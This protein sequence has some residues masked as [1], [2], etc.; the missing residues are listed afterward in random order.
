MKRIYFTILLSAIVLMS[1]CKKELVEDSRSEVTDNY[2]STPDGIQAAVNAA[3]SL[4]R[5]YWGTEL[6]A[7]LSV[8]GTDEYTAGS[9]ADRD[10]N[11]YNNNLNPVKGN[12]MTAWANFY[13]GINACNAVINRAPDV[14]MD[15]TLKTTRVAEARFLRAQYYFMLVQMWGPVHITLT[16][17]K[18]AV[19]TAKRSPVAEV[20]KVITDDLD[21]AIANLPVTSTNYGRAIKPAAQHLAAKV[22]LTRAGINNDQADYT[23]AADLA[24]AV[25]NG[26]TNKLLDNFADIFVQGAGERNTETI[27]SVQYSNNLL[28]NG[29][30]NTLHLYFVFNYDL[31]PGMQR[32]L[33]GGRP[34]KRY[35]PT[36]FALNTL[37]NHQTDGR[38]DATFKRVYYSNKAGTYTING[39]QVN[40]KLGDTAIFFP[41]VE[42]TAAQ[43]ATK[44]Y[45]VFPP[46][47][48]TE[49][50]FP[51]LTKFLDPTRTD[52]NATSGARD[53]ILYRLGETYLIAAEALLM[54]GKPDEALTYINTL[55]RR[56]AK[57][58]ATDAA[59]AAN[60][61]AMEVTA[62]Q[63]NLDFIL[64]ERARE[65]NGEHQ[66][67][68]DLARTKTL[69][70]RVKL[71]NSLGA[72]NIKDYHLLRPIPQTQIDR[73]D[74]GV[75]AF[76]QNPGY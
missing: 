16:E 66:R 1:A 46:S 70:A 76:P 22:Y 26:N 65:L 75:T 39:H 69:V 56:A 54:S 10:F 5:N 2:I 38:F 61:T 37:Y 23:K 35:K 43:I 8:T 12:F 9:D 7:N 28:T 42:L 27:Y 18:G 14:T 67:W 57:K 17:T 36:A 44:N 68:F 19:T 74:G 33:A 73:T 20:Y 72:P 29:D 40:M 62:A 63:L 34:Y 64:D 45:S 41:D 50:T 53:F 6:G 13:Q 59:T 55:R 49:A 32:D 47:K 15:A 4:Q 71:Y 30:G 31:L 11:A 52:A 25:I 21:F 60:R 51:T 58:G 3:Y 48:V 24:K